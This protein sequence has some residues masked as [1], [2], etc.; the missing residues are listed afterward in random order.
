MSIKFTN[1]SIKKNENYYELGVKKYMTS[2]YLYMSF[3]LIL[4]FL[5]AIIVSNYQELM[6]V[7]HFSKLRWLIIF[8][9]LIM[10]FYI[11]NKLNFMSKIAVQMY[12][13]I[14]SSLIGLSLSFIF[15]IFTCE[16]ILKILFI[17]SLIFF[18]MSI[19]AHNAKVDLS[20]VH[21]FLIMITIGLIISGT[22]NIFLRSSFIDF[23]SSIV[24]VLVFT[25]F[26]I[27]DT[28]KIKLLYYQNKINSNDAFN[29]AV[30]GSLTLY[31]DFINIFIFLI[32]LIAV[33]RND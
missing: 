27:Y 28:Q 31:M 1:I 5:V 3:S 25:L 7:I 11:N 2:V 9:P 24:G 17:S 10:S 32:K 29:L 12:L 16:S 14:F 20:P 18:F 19:Y 23:S 21:S 13:I 30:Y 6:Y 4:T 22:I 8:S 26:T 15:F 33:K